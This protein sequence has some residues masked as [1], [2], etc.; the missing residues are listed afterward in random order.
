ME[1]IHG[2][3]VSWLHHSP[4]GAHSSFE[5][6]MVLDVVG[7]LTV[8]LILLYMLTTKYIAKTTTQ[9]ATPSLRQPRTRRHSRTSKII[10]MVKMSRLRPKPMDLILP[11]L[12]V[13]NL[14]LIASSVQAQRESSQVQTLPKARKILK[15]L[16]WAGETRGCQA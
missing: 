7:R 5:A 11:S 8:D 15:Q 13:M 16:H 14:V 2:V 1:G 3:D 4:K 9:K 10:Y 12:K 6:Q